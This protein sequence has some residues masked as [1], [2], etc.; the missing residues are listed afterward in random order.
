[1]GKNVIYKYE[2]CGQKTGWDY[3][4]EFILPDASD[5]N[6]P[7]TIKL[8][9]GS[10]EATQMD[11]KYDKYPLGCGETPQLSITVHL[12]DIP[13]TANFNDFRAAIVN[14]RIFKAKQDYLQWDLDLGIV[15]ILSIKYNKNSEPSVNIWR[16]LFKGICKEDA[17]IS[18][19]L[20]KM[21]AELKFNYLYKTAMES[22]D[23]KGDWFGF[24]PTWVNDTIDQIIEYRVNSEKPATHDW[25]PSYFQFYRFDTIAKY[26]DYSIGIVLHSYM[27]QNINYEFNSN[28][29]PKLYKQKYD[30]SGERG[31]ELQEDEI[32]CIAA[33]E[34]G[35]A[36]AGLNVPSDENSLA[37]RY[38]S[39][40]NYIT[41]AAEASMKRAIYHADAIDF[42]PC[43]GYDDII[44]LNLK[45][46]ISAKI[47]TNADI[48]RDVKA[49]YPERYSDDKWQDL[50]NWEEVDVANRNEGGYNITCLWNNM[51]ICEGYAQGSNNFYNA[52]FRTTGLYYIDGNYA[53]RVHEYVNFLIKAGVLSEILPRCAPEYERWDDLPQNKPSERILKNQV[54]SN[55][56]RWLASA[57]LSI[58][59]NKEQAKL[60]LETQYDWN[61]WFAAGGSN[62]MFWWNGNMAFN[63]AMTDDYPIQ[64]N[65][66]WI[67]ISSE[68][69]FREERVKM[70]LITINI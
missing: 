23:F 42:M 16:P 2:W 13:A 10:I 8:P 41:E 33:V 15:V 63:I 7:T 56:G 30:G 24:D 51:P 28:L 17:N 47:T 36:I 25:K 22:A 20:P 57:I 69:D 53:Y 43:Y 46:H 68:L 50:D 12:S 48:L 58:F 55:I 59:G 9:P 21:D 26:I 31:A 34:K 65:K 67:P 14:P 66:K 18:I 45:D 6:N 62:G 40:W 35:E 29:L 49:S 60:E 37:A 39:L 64:I 1:M 11:W 19:E 3:R 4:L 27:R 52:I 32:Y 61:I 54:T 44:D 70:E 5:L 38:K